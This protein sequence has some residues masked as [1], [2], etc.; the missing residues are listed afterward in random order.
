MADSRAFP[1]PKEISLFVGTGNRNLTA[2]FPV[3]NESNKLYDYEAFFSS[4][5]TS[6]R[7]SSFSPSPEALIASLRVAFIS[8]W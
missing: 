8:V 4:S 1:I 7:T 2:V 5:R 3:P 6:L